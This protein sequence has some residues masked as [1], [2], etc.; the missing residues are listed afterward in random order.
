MGCIFVL[1]LGVVCGVCVDL[2]DVLWFSRLW[3][4]LFVAVRFLVVCS[5]F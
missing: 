2:V 3:I 4:L 5:V 1:V